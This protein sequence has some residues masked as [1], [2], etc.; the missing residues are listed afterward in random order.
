MDSDVQVSERDSV[1]DA[2]FGTCGLRIL[3][4]LRRII[5]GVDIHSRKLYS[6]FNVTTPQMMCLYSLVS[7][8]A[9][10]LSELA[11]TVHLSV[12]TVNGIVDRIEKRGWARRER[13]AKDRR[14]VYVHVT[15]AGRKLASN[16]PALLQNRLSERLR[17]L[18]EQEQAAI[19]LSLERIVEF[20]EV[21][22]LEASPILTPSLQIAPT[23]GEIK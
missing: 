9:V 12:S 18:P 6:D 4:A 8:G 20:M 5:R 11:E 3:R 13:C 22:D 1:S 14:R 2:F 15:D 16:A 23:H 10:T 21:E 17:Q 19:A 7:K